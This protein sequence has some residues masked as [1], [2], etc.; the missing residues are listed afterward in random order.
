[1]KGEREG[2]VTPAKPERGDEGDGEDEW[3]EMMSV[4]SPI[5]AVVRARLG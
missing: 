2:K 5:D 1:M 3:V 4:S